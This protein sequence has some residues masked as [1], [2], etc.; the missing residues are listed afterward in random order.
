MIFSTFV[1]ATNQLKVIV[2]M[3]G[4]VTT[5]IHCHEPCVL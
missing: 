2:V 5:R 1:I 4:D 3:R